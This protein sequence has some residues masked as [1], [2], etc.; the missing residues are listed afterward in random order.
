MISQ[1]CNDTGGSRCKQGTYEKTYTTSI[2][3]DSVVIEDNAGNKRTCTYGVYVDKEAPTCGNIAK[4]NNASGS[5]YGLGSLT[6]SNVYTS[7]VCTYDSGGSGC[8]STKTL[9]TRGNTTNITNELRNQ[10]TV[11]ASGVSYM[12]WFVYDNAG[13]STDCGVITV[14]KGTNSSSSVCGCKTA[15]QCGG[16][17]NGCASWGGWVS[18]QCYSNGTN[19]CQNNKPGNTYSKQWRCQSV[20]GCNQMLQYRTCNSYSYSD[21][22]ECG[23]AE[24]NTCCHE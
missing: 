19:T 3:T 12:N 1:D 14:K 22:Y 23:C 9:T 18:N 8:S 6:C 15:K 24:Y 20:S 16:S 17:I 5:D 13:N 7:A 10:W 2:G 11:E 4:L 21:T